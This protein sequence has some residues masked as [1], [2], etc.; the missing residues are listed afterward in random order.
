MG[1]P[2]HILKGIIPISGPYDVRDRGRPGELYTY[3]PTPELREQASPILHITDPV[4][5]VLVAVGGKEKYIETS[6]LFIEKL[7]AANVD[8][9]YLLLNDENHAD[10]AVSLSDADSELFKHTIALIKGSSS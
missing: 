10:T 5:K 6:L 3:A 2:K 7:K 1:I 9:Q 4:P 8:A